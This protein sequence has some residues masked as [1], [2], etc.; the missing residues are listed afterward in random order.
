MLTLLLLLTTPAPEA[1]DSLRAR[2]TEE[3]VRH[4]EC[5]NVVRIVE[6]SIRAGK[7]ISAITEEL[8]AHCEK[9]LDPRKNIC[10]ALVPAHVSNISDQLSAKQRPDVIC[11]SLGFARH[12]GGGRVVSKAQCIRY[13]DLARAEINESK[14]TEEKDSGIHLPRPFSKLTD[15]FRAGGLRRFLGLTSACKDVP[16][17]EKIECHVIARLFN[18]ALRDS[19]D[20]DGTSAE[21]CQKLNE[22]HLIKLSDEESPTTPAPPA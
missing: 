20:K 10:R 7:D 15:A 5:F 12:F 2:T 11:E 1:E 22:R 9:L 17:N 4:F 21:I 13:V 14:A 6:H 18:R 19:G 3:R 16:G 8:S